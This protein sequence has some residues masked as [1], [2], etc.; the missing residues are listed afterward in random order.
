MV[1]AVLLA[2]IVLVVLVAGGGQD[3]GGSIPAGATLVEYQQQVGE[4]CTELNRTNRET[5]RR[6]RPYQRRLNR[7]D[8]LTALRDVIVEETQQRIG[9]AGSMR[10]HLLGLEP[11]DDETTARQRATARAWQ[12]NVAA[13]QAYRDGLK[14]V[15]SY[16][17]L[18]RTVRSFDSRRT[19][20]ERTSADIRAGLQRLGGPACDLKTPPTAKPV[21]LPADPD[22]KP[23]EPAETPSPQPAPAP[24]AQG[25][26]AP[27]T[28]PPSTGTTPPDSSPPPAATPPPPDS[29][30]PPASAPP[31]LN[32]PSGGGGAGEG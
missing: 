2:A 24:S 21:S 7:A 3:G 32:V 16:R 4:V 18:V 14:D 28:V 17:E 19:S 12:A 11:P 1:L 9:T 8:D 22:A 10:A 5:A 20:V 26:P 15:G 25:S 31:D 23:K 27:D 30:P 29:S 6:T 13:F